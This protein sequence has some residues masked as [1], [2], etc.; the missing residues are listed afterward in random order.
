[1]EKGLEW[2][3]WI[4]WVLGLRV[5]SSDFLGMLVAMVHCGSADLVRGAG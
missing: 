3:I 1:M 5:E 4:F 2:R